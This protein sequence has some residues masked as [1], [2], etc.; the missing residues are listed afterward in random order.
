M[1]TDNE[2]SAS[3]SDGGV[4]A[5]P[6]KKRK[7]AAELSPDSLAAKRDQNNAAQQRRRFKKKSERTGKAGVARGDP[8][9]QLVYGKMT[10][11]TFNMHGP[12]M[13]EKLQQNLRRAISECILEDDPSDTRFLRYT[14]KGKRQKMSPSPSNADQDDGDDS[15]EDEATGGAGE[16]AAEGEGQPHIRSRRGTSKT[17]EQGKE[18]ASVSPCL[19]LA[20]TFE[21]ALSAALQGVAAAKTDVVSL[22][23]VREGIEKAMGSKVSG[24]QKQRI[25]AAVLQVTEN[26]SD[27]DEDADAG[28]EL[29]HTEEE[30]T[31]DVCLEAPDIDVVDP[32]KTG[33]SVAAAEELP[34]GVGAAADTTA[35]AT[36]QHEA[37]GGALCGPKAFAVATPAVEGTEEQAEARRVAKPGA[38]V[39][40]GDGVVV[41]SEPI[42]RPPRAAK[43]EGARRL[44][45]WTASSKAV[46]KGSVAQDTASKTTAGKGTTAAPKATAAGAAKPSARKPS[47]KVAGAAAAAGGS[48][49]SKTARRAAGLPGEQPQHSGPVVLQV[50]QIFTSKV[51][52]EMNSVPKE[53]YDVLVRQLLQK[54]KGLPDVGEM[55]GK[56]Q[57]ALRLGLCK[58]REIAEKRKFTLPQKTMNKVLDLQK[59][60]MNRAFWPH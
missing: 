32:A 60:L 1:P 56:E 33:D 39:V 23:A 53:E 38:H 10:G 30:G 46:T 25:K 41:A 43:T 49:T 24:E 13:T 28:T 2:A 17:S 8:L 4:P 57:A 31:T 35:E 34:A 51:L 6:A 44:Q 26:T 47:S 40:P 48:F 9:I 5:Q 15:D 18:M 59:Q 19:T 22:K 14:S 20:W 21:D 52:L 50:E 36:T 7:R 16:Q 58:V 37:A 3:G 27:L 55:C 42:G 54:A 12:Y 45:K 11:L 29:A